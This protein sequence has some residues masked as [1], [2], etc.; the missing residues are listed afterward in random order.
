M[1]ASL[2]HDALIAGGGPAGSTLAIALAQAGRQTVLMERSREAHH[3]VCGEFLSPE[4][5]PLLRQI[6]VDPASLG[7]QTI[8]SVRIAASEI[9]AEMPLPSPAMSLTRRALDEALLQRARQAG[10]SLLRGYTVEGLART[11]DWSTKDTWCARMTNGK[12]TAFSMQGRDVFLATGK[13]DLRGWKRSAAGT[14]S[15]L[16]ALKMYFMLAPAQQAQLSGHVEL[17]FFSGGYAGF[18]MVEGNA[19]NLCVLVTRRKLQALGNRWDRL[20]LSL[21]NASEHLRRRLDGAT[22]LLERPLALSNIP[23]GFCAGQATDKPSPWRLGD[24]AAVIPSLLGDGMAIALHSAQQAARLYLEGRDS[25]TFHTEMRNQ[26]RDRLSITA[27]LSRLIVS[28]PGIVQSVR[29][30][31]PMLSDIFA[32]T[33][34]AAPCKARG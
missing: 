32:A 19:A 17:V 11:S 15:S 7:A 8:H 9:L 12:Q 13:H 2:C 14:H 30:W 18:Q 34:L 31:P 26:F 20:L 22:P 23:Y 6:G 29:L 25:R 5:L 27:K 10:V 24:Q 1:I 16:V 28:V 21:E 33:R 3:K 4:S